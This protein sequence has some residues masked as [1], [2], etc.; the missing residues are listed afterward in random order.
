M[1]EW[2]LKINFLISLKHSSYI[3]QEV[4][5]QELT[6]KLENLILDQLI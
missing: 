1:K 4:F 3:L 6:W 2:R 5:K